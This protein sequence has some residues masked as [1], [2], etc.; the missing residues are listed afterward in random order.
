MLRQ[1]GLELESGKSLA[2]SDLIEAPSPKFPI[3][4]TQLQEERLWQR[5]SKRGR[6]RGWKRSYWRRGYTGNTWPQSDFPKWTTKQRMRACLTRGRFQAQ[7]EAL[8]CVAQD[9]VIQTNVYRT[10]ITNEEVSPQCR[11]CEAEETIGHIVVSCQEY[12]TRQDTIGSFTS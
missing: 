7:T 6:P 1:Y 4:L 8:V 3:Y 9:Q 12:T 2:T 5:N 11:R 10:K